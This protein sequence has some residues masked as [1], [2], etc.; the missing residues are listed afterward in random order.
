MPKTN[1]ISAYLEQ[2]T[3]YG[4]SP[5]FYLDCANYL[6][7]IG[8]RHLAI[9]VLTN[10]AELDLES[11]QL[12]RIL[13]Y[14]LETERELGL[15]T[16]ILDQVLAMRP[17]EPQSY[18]D[19]AL[20]LDRR[21]EF[22]RAAELLW[23]VVTGDWD[24]RFPEIETLALMELNRILERAR[25]EGQPE[26]AEELGIDQRLLKL[27]DQDLRVVLSWDA[28]LTDV[29]LWVTEPNGEKCDFSHNRTRM[30]GRLSRDF[31]Q[32]YGPEEYVLRRGMS[33]VYQI[34]AN[35]YGSSQ[36]TLTGPA[37]VLATVFTNFGRPDEDRQTLTVRVTDVKDVI[38]VGEAKL[39]TR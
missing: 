7:K 12:L 18:R 38:D 13:A 33:G 30:G 16:R 4:R 37:T 1:S 11:P 2:R 25:R 6:F 34:Q 26:I 20:V 14:K 21:G 8:Q 17:E 24:D 28:D 19:L 23:T 31:T 22:R 36:Q 15:T 5:S 9:R 32:G 10:V 29:D 35:Y 27:L 3:A 39:R